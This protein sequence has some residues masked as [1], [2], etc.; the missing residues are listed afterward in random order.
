MNGRNK[1]DGVAFGANQ[2]NFCVEN[3]PGGT[4]PGTE[5]RPVSRRLML[6]MVS[7]MFR[8]LRLRQPA[9]GKNAE[10]KQN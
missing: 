1:R 9:D 2:D 5:Q 8:G 7:G 3:R 6:R 10:D 4:H